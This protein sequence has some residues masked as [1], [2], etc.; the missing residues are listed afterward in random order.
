[1]SKYH[2]NPETGRPNICRA[3]TPERCLYVINGVTPEH[4]SSKEEAYKGFEFINSSETLVSISKKEE[5]YP[6]VSIEP[7]LNN[8]NQYSVDSNFDLNLTKSAAKFLKDFN[9]LSFD[10][11]FDNYRLDDFYYS[12]TV[13]NY[14]EGYY[15]NFSL[16]TSEIS[17][18]ELTSSILKN[19][20][21]A[22]NIGKDSSES[23][24]IKETVENFRN[25][26]PEGFYSIQDLVQKHNLSFLD[27]FDIEIYSG[28]YGDEIAGNSLTDFGRRNYGKFYNELQEKVYKLNN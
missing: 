14:E 6:Q 4:Y 13:N 21:S 19:I 5:F 28:H 7:D 11:V 22:Q 20:V 27:N 2:I 12:E 3:K 17:D 24:N 26:D 9:K 10:D 23:Y 25:N 16:E 8:E 1:M 18:N 15:R